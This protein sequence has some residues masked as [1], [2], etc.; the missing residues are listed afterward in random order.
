[1][2]T[3]PLSENVSS[4]EKRQKNDRKEEVKTFI[5]KR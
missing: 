3:F 5:E 1:M 4:Q 2:M